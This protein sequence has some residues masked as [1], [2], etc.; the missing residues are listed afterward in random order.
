MHNVLS[1]VLRGN[2]RF[3]NVYIPLRVENACIRNKSVRTTAA[4]ITNY[5][6]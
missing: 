4:W 1:I 6:T 3:V 2:R 5:L